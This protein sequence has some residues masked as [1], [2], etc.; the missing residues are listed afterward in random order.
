MGKDVKVIISVVCFKGNK[1]LILK[2]S[3]K[4]EYF[5]SLW[6]CG[7]GRLEPGESFQETAIREVKEETGYDIDL[8]QLLH[9]FSFTTENSTVP[10]LSF[11]AKIKEDKEPVITNEHDEYKFIGL[12]EI[13]N[14]TFGG[15]IGKEIK[16][17]FEIMGKRG[18]N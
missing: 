12:E 15:D 16:A 5:P 13:N 8:V 11:I 9:A 7:G 18:F 10:V 14:Y 3:S 1:V 4:K 17:A 6:E 2:R